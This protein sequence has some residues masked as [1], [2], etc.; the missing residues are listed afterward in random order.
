MAIKQ[1][2][3]TNPARRQQTVATFDELSTRQPHKPLTKG[4]KRIGGRNNRGRITI[5]YRGGGHKRRYR[6][7]DFR[8]DKTG[9]PAK[10]ASIEYDPNR[11]AR[12]SLLH[13]ADGEKRYILWPHGLA[14]G[15]EVVSGPE[16]PINPG[17]ALPL[18]SIPVGTVVHNLE[19][20]IGKGGQRRRP[21]DG[22]G[23]P[24]RPREAAV[25]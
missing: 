16:A 21:A 7:V 15:D 17:N 19:L 23:G 13:Y 22:Q 5:W 3:P 6:V 24:V 25:G 20:K 14:V 11:S 10:V 2:K 1:H 12:I 8:R 4:V 18:R 9:V